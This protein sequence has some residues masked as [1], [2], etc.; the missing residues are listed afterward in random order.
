MLALR[1]VVI[2]RV[3]RAATYSNI[4][5]PSFAVISRRNIGIGSRLLSTLEGQERTAER[6][7]RSQS[8]CKSIWCLY[9]SCVGSNQVT[10]CNAHS[11]TA[12]ELFDAEP[13]VSIFNNDMIKQWIAAKNP[14][15][16]EKGMKVSQPKMVDSALTH[17]GSKV[18]PPPSS[19]FFVIAAT[20]N[21]R[22]DTWS[23]LAHWCLGSLSW[24]WLS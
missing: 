5:I 21:I 23:C 17:R 24:K 19:S 14:I 7:E 1:R 3:R 16:I 20:E 12:L 6:Q 4:I 13:V 9:D 22:G 11:N 2:G 10:S 15:A 8:N 18:V